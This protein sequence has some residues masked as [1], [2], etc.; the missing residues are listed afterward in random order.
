M[1]NSGAANCAC[2]MP[3]LVRT[4]R[5]FVPTRAA[6]ALPTFA[7]SRDGIERSFRL[8]R[9]DCHEFGTLGVAYLHPVAWMLVMRIEF[10]FLSLLLPIYIHHCL[11][12]FT[13][14]RE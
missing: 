5:M 11:Q 8:F 7:V 4:S 10:T 3:S 12:G 6:T 1:E 2:V 13:I 14:V 9:F